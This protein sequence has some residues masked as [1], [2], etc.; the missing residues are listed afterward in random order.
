[1]WI[2]LIFIFS[3]FIICIVALT[4]HVSYLEK[5]LKQCI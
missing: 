2:A 3:F 5:T 4:H 1:M